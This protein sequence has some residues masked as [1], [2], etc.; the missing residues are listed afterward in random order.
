MKPFETYSD[1]Y[2]SLAAHLKQTAIEMH[3]EHKY[4]PNYTAKLNL[5]I[6]RAY[7]K[8]ATEAGFSSED[9]RDLAITL[10]DFSRDY[11]LGPSFYVNMLV[12]TLPDEF[13][14]RGKWT[15]E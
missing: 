6:H 1:A 14:V 7:Q 9:M 15:P 12:S 10:S 5:A 3:H 11:V 13:N 8:W 2:L 4:T